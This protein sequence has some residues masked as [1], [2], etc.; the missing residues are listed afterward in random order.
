MIMLMDYDFM[1]FVICVLIDSID[2][3]PEYAGHLMEGINRPT[4]TPD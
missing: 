2:E 1:L 4:W 3:L